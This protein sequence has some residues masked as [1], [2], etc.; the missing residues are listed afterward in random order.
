MNLHML[1]L[2]LVV[3][4][5]CA[6]V[7]ETTVGFAVEDS[8]AESPFSFTDDRELLN[9]PNSLAG[10]DRIAGYWITK[11]FSTASKDRSRFLEIN[12]S[13]TV[14]DFDNPPTGLG[15]LFSGIF[16]RYQSGTCDVLVASG[17]GIF[18]NN[19]GLGTGNPV[20]MVMGK[21]HGTGGT[22][23]LLSLKPSSYDISGSSPEYQLP[24][25]LPTSPPGN[26]SDRFKLRISADGP[27]GSIVKFENAYGV[28]T[29][30]QKTGQMDL[31][32]TC[33]APFVNNT[34][35][36]GFLTMG[37]ISVVHQP[38]STASS[39]TSDADIRVSSG[40]SVANQNFYFGEVSSEDVAVTNHSGVSEYWPFFILPTPSNQGSW[41]YHQ[42]STSSVINADPDCYNE[43]AFS[44]GSGIQTMGRGDETAGCP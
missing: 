42:L 29:P 25:L 2:L 28:N 17:V 24:N 22:P 5:G 38:G 6:G 27:D 40:G 32:T 13:M 41:T 12:G 30:L 16:F 9:Y 7:D 10:D 44:D 34:P 14:R 21:P 20:Y 11:S 43:L 1:I 23:F 31:D 36:T 26:F 8:L 37:Y 3:L 18:G 39:W 19:Y 35:T 33:W 15:Y 4:V